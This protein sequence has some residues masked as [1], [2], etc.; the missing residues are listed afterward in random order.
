MSHEFRTVSSSKKNLIAGLITWVILSLAGLYG[1]T[2]AV[3]TCLFFEGVIF[4][5]CAVALIVT[6]RTKWILDFK[7]ADLVITNTGNRRSYGFDRL[8]RED[9]VFTQ[10]A[11]QKA[12][13]RGHLKI[14]GSSA[15]F[16]D[17][18]DFE[19]LKAYI[20]EHFD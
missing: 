6:V 13:N 12:K 2:I 8:T 17:V 9:F 16:N 14:R 11:R 20:Q 18:K 3:I 15:V 19:E 1:L 4:L 5:C 10:S 7:G